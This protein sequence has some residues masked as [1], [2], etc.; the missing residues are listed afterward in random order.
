MTGWRVVLGGRRGG[1]LRAEEGLGWVM[2]L[3]EE[4]CWLLLDDER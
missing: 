3:A 4:G 1:D 2:V